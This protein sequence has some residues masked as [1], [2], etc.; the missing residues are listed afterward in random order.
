MEKHHGKKAEDI[1]IDILNSSGWSRITDVKRCSK[2]M[3]ELG[4]DIKYDWMGI[5]TYGQIKSYSF[6]RDYA[7]RRESY[8]LLKRTIK[9][10]PEYK[11]V[12]F[13]IYGVLRRLKGHEGTNKF[14]IMMI[15]KLDDIWDG[16]MEAMWKSGKIKNTKTKKGDEKWVIEN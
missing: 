12:R 10:Y 2:K 4:I 11:N 5:T 14:R 6:W 7:A 13:I 15:K 8:A 9:Q 16:E 3:D 1:I